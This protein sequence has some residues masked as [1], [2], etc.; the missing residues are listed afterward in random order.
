MAEQNG[1][2]RN[3]E[4]HQKYKTAY[5]PNDFYWG[6]GVEHETYFETSKLKQITLKGL[7]EHTAPE[8]YCVDYY[9]VYTKEHLSHAL[10]GLFKDTENILIPILLNSHTFQKTDLNGEHS[11]TYTRLPKPNPKFSGKTIFEW[12]EEE[13]LFF[14]REYGRSY[15]FDGDTIEF[16]TQKYYKARVN[17][18]IDELTLIENKFIEQL[19]A[20]PKEGLLKTYT[21]F[22]I[23][24]QN[25]PFAAYLTNLKNNAMFNNGTIHINITLPTKLND[26]GVPA[27][28]ELFTKQH[29]NYARAFQWISPLL[30][31]KYGAYDPLCEATTN[32][33]KYA[34]GSQRIAVS[35]YIGLGTYDT[36]KMEIG[37]ILTKKR[38]QL[39]NIEWYTEFHK[40]ADYEFLDDLGLDIN[41][42]KHFS[43]GLEFRIFESLPIADIKTIITALVYLADF[44][45]ETPLENP[46][47]S[48]L[49]NRIALECV[50]HGKGYILNVSDQNEL[51]TIFGCPNLSKEPLYAPDV[52]ENITT[53]LAKKYKNGLCAKC[54]IE[55]NDPHPP[56]P[57]P[58]KHHTPLPRPAQS[59]APQPPP[60]PKK[61]PMWLCC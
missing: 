7:K 33:E 56:A 36:D 21:P 9:S 44:S 55:G 57:P 32:G 46:K 16:M 59:A 54:M 45:L 27:D 37:K 6:L 19:N 17:D 20:L 5:K 13:N 2:L 25:Y 41:F 48:K 12:M 31:A 29:Q 39:N 18:V 22:Q 51:Y 34:A 61:K 11:T 24:K 53:H 4:K 43:H 60:P 23:A 50:H 1:A 42:N 26:Q 10:D 58:I 52:L 40:R 35:R 30:I 3:L 14:A 38:A 15:I 47:K 49:W 8:R 28:F